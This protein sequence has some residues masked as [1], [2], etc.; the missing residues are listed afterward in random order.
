MH[1]PFTLAIDQLALI[2]F[3]K[4]LPS[5]LALIESERDHTTWQLAE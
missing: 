5:N 4:F 2:N 1:E 3:A